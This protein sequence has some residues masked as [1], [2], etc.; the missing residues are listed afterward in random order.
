[1]RIINDFKVGQKGG[2]KGEGSSSSSRENNFEVD[3][4][5]FFGRNDLD[6]SI[7]KEKDDIFKIMKDGSERAVVASIQLRELKRASFDR[8]LFTVKDQLTNTISVGD[9]VRVLDGPLKPSVDKDGMFSIGQSLRI[10]V[11]PLKGYL[12]RVLAI[13]RFDVTV[14]LD[15]QQKILTD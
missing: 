3:D 8:K 11:E 12:C 13:R 10:Q 14:K 15:S 9:M 5:I 4:L 2:D 1:M 7:G 6:T